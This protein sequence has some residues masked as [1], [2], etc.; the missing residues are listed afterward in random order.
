MA[1]QQE[2]VVNGNNNQYQRAEFD[3]VEDEKLDWVQWNKRRD[4]L[5]GRH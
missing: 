3:M 2:I 1:A 5:L 4:K